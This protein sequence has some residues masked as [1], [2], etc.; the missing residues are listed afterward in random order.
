MKLLQFKLDGGQLHAAYRYASARKVHLFLLW[1]CHWTF[2]PQ[3]QSVHLRPQMHLPISWK[4]D[5]ISTGSL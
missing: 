1:S 4:L 3:K 2:W 5:E